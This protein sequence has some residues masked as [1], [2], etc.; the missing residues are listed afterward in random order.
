MGGGP[1]QILNLGVEMPSHRRP[2]GWA[3]G[4]DA[5][6]GG[7]IGA[8]EPV[9][10]Q[11]G[12]AI[13]VRP[14][15]ARGSRFARRN[16]SA[17]GSGHPTSERPAAPPFTSGPRTSSGPDQIRRVGMRC[18]SGR[19]PKAC[20]LAFALCL[21]ALLSSGHGSKAEG[22]IVAGSTPPSVQISQDRLEKQASCG[23]HYGSRHCTS[24]VACLWEC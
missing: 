15:L 1:A 22:K 18:F 21:P 4:F 19:L 11:G 13:G 2:S 17:S 14:E 5:D 3:E 16:P 24:G 12:E 8:V 6:C 10:P 23:S 7:N 9:R 20:A